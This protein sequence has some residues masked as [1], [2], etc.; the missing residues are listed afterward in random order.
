VATLPAFANVGLRQDTKKAPAR[1]GQVL[2]A[3]LLIRLTI[4]DQAIA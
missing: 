3:K 4:S 1:R 2:V